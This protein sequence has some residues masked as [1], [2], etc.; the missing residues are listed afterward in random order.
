MQIPDSLITQLQP[1]RILI[2]GAAREGLASYHF[3]RKIFPDKKLT[4]ADQNLEAQF[5]ESVLTELKQDQHLNLIFGPQ[6]LQNLDKFSLIIK[7]PGI[8]E[9]LPE[10]QKALKKGVNLSSNLELFFKLLNCYE[11][12]QRPLTIG[13]TGTKGKSTTSSLLHHILKLTDF[14]TLLLGNIGNPALDALKQISDKTLIILE[15]S[16]HQLANLD[17]SPDIAII[18]NITSEHLDYYPSTEAYVEAKSAICKYQNQDGLVIYNPEFPKTK[19]LTKASAG[20]ALTYQLDNKNDS[21][22]YIKDNYLILNHNKFNAI[23]LPSRWPF[24]KPEFKNDIKIIKIDELPLLGKHNLQ[25]IAPSL[26]VANLLGIKP[27]A[28]TKALL[29]F[30]P[31]AHRLEPVAKINGVTF[32]NDSLATMPEATMAAIEAFEQKIILIAG[33]YERQQDF[34]HLAKLIVQQ[35]LKALILLPTT[36]ERLAQDVQQAAKKLQLPCP[37]I[38]LVNSMPEAV[39][40]AKQLAKTGELV[41]MSPASAS[42]GMFRDYA[43]RGKQFKEAINSK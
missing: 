9:L 1:E 25:N 26:I 2:L 18:Q 35:G 39:T 8:N 28:L 31:L 6:Y 17:Y 22:I 34:S 43:D 16:C 37:K 32:I 36:G 38:H 20:L 15:L 7:T 19:K 40:I 5:S 11:P 13:V 30:V 23:T 41:L 10:I 24:V 12:N 4:L 33:G 42:F 29:S 27:A 3:L 14:D 21:L